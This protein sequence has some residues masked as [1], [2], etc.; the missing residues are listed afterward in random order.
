[1][2]L[3]TPGKSEKLKIEQMDGPLGA[4]II[5]LN[6]QLTLQTLFEFQN[7]SRQTTTQALVLD[8][9]GVPYMDSAG[10]GALISLFAACQR[11]N[12]GF[13]LTGLSDRIRTLF[14]ITH[15]DGLLPCFASVDA[16]EAAAV[17][18]AA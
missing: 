4:R 2:K 5:K 13:A 12:R 3:V 17:K 10:L 8:I 7:A 6:G 9:G 1:L 16:A 15:V 11:T 14:E 18:S